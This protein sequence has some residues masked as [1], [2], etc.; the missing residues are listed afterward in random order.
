MTRGDDRVVENT[1]NLL[2]T[3]ISSTHYNVLSVGY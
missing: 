2:E 3:G 1:H